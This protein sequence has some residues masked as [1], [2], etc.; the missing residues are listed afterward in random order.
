[1]EAITFELNTKSSAIKEIVVFQLQ[2]FEITLIILRDLTDETL[3]T[4]C[5]TQIKAIQVQSS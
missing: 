1:M 5:E 4:L 3:W 2:V